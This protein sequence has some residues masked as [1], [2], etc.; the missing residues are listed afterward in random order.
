MMTKLKPYIIGI[1]VLFALWL[2]GTLLV[3]SEVNTETHTTFDAP[4]EYIYNVIN[5]L[6]L[7]R[8]ISIMKSDPS[9]AMKCKNITKGKNSQCSYTSE[10]YGN[11]GFEII[12]NNADTIYIKQNIESGFEKNYT[13]VFDPKDSTHTDVHVFIKSKVSKLKSL[14]KYFFA[15]SL[16]SESE[17]M[18][19][20]AKLIV[21]D[22]QKLS[23][24]NGFY[25][26]NEAFNTRYFIYNAETVKGENINTYYTQTLSALYQ[27]AIKAGI[28]PSG[29]AC[30]LYLGWND[31]LNMTT[32]AAA[33]PVLSETNV[34]FAKS[35]TIPTQQAAVIEFV[36]DLRGLG[37][38]HVAIDDYVN[39][40]GLKI[41]PPVIEEYISDPSISPNENTWKTNIIYCVKPR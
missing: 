14:F 8:K 13:Y 11:G 3:S 12:Q 9:F 27:N 24:Y 36:G 22:R 5:D 18:M 33:I 7:Q 23:L 40:R 37:L 25:V 30:K 15:S 34:S 29:P 26:K 41:N 19:E 10:K 2:I 21:D 32:I 1:G 4:K 38:A 28:T 31:T 6:N 16:K 20:N 35:L 17:E 39:D